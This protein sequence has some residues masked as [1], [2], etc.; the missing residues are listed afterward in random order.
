[1]RVLFISH[2]QTKP[3]FQYG[4]AGLC[5]DQIVAASPDDIDVRILCRSGDDAWS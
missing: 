1:M 4:G 3:G 5:L 2:E